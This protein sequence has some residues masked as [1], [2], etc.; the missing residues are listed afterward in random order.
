MSRSFLSSLLSSLCT[1]GYSIINEDVQQSFTALSLHYSLQ[2]WISRPS[3]KNQASSGCSF[4]STTRL[5]INCC[6]S[7]KIS[8]PVL[9]VPYTLLI[10]TN[11]SKTLGGYIILR[12]QKS[13]EVPRVRQT[14]SLS[15][16]NSR[17]LFND[18]SL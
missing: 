13:S 5:E 8:H 12:Y 18:R 6:I 3:A 1:P 10:S 2:A 16:Q 4:V 14:S 15:Y 17:L 11:V 9:P 7:L